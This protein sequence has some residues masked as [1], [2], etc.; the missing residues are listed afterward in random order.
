VSQEP[1]V[2]DLTIAENISY[3]KENISMEQIIEAATKANIHE[4]IKQLPQVSERITL[5]TCK[6]LLY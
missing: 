4:F 6:H 3:A 5:D 1:I 2:F